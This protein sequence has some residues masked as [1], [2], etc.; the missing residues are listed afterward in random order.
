MHERPVTDR[1]TLAV[2][3]VGGPL[4]L[5]SVATVVATLVGTPDAA[6]A[7]VHLPWF[8]IAVLFALAQSFTINIQVKREARSISL[9]D[10]PFVLGLLALGPGAFV[11]AR[12]VGGAFAQVAVRRQHREPLKLAFNVV[13]SLA[14]AAAGLAVFV[15]LRGSGMASPQTWVAAVLGAAAANAVS[16]LSVAI[17]IARLESSWPGIRALP[18]VVGEAGGRAVP[19][20]C[21]GLVAAL[22]LDVSLWTAVPLALVC[23]TVL[24]GYRAYARLI[25]RHLSLE[26]LYRFSQVVA[27]HTATEEIFTGMLEQ[28]CELLFADGADVTFFD[29]TGRPETELSLRRDHPVE[30]RDPKH[31]TADCGWLLDAVG[32]DGRP[33]LLSRDTKDVVYRHWLGAAGFKEAMLVPLRRDGD[34]VGVLT[35]ID[36]MGAARGFERADLRLLETVANQASIAA[37]NGELMDRLRHDSLHDALT[38][39]ANRVFLQS[40]VDRLLIELGQGGAPFAVAMLDLD[41]FKEVNDTLGHQHGDALLQEVARRLTVAVDGRGIVTRFGGDEFAVLLPN[42]RSDDMVARHC[43]TVLDFLAPP[44]E[45]DG[46]AIDIGASIGVARAPLHGDTCDELVKRADVAMYVAKQAGR[47]VVIFDQSQDTASPARLALV[48][49]LRQAISDES[50]FIHVQPQLRF[51]ANEVVSVEAL[52]RWSDAERGFV[53]PDEFIPLAERSGLIRPLTDFVL[54]QAIAACAEWQQHSPGVA[55]SVNLSARSLHDD[56]LDEQIERV[57]RRHGVPGHL[58]T[59]EI[60]ESSVMADPAGT[61]GLLHRLRALGVRLSI[62]DFGTGYSSLAYLR[63]LPVQEVK[64]DRA[65]VQR[66]DE[67]ADDAAIVRSIVELARTLD[68]S[69]VAEG[70]ENRRAMLLLEEMGCAMV[71]GYHIARPMPVA[72]FA[73][74]HR[75]ARANGLRQRLISVAES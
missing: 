35:V 55:V 19:P 69:V 49:A 23:A 17:L 31:V 32:R 67:E 21:I 34:V 11:A 28:V 38:G 6:V 73:D 39:I 33:L 14:E 60:T 66:M 56:G 71:Q 42:C 18:V 16:G 44:V 64:V 3:L 74:W 46:T 2:G 63:R 59:L 50:L 12:L 72:E 75:Q 62:D 1:S 8:V 68:L 25:D 58:L 15:A 27:D 37:R 48:A 10:A 43:R 4:L 41:S 40:E 36:R 20:A 9:S 47:D 51:D 5:A 30:H 57:L 13:T 7:S 54:E 61:L 26:R 53:P 52:V 29:R 24:A 45:L 70:V 65:F 22:C